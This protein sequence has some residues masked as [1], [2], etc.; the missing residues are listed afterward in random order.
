MRRPVPREWGEPRL[1][2]PDYPE[3]L[4]IVAGLERP[5][6]V[7]APAAG[8]TRLADS[9]ARATRWFWVKLDRDW[10]WNLAR[11]LAYTCLQALFAVMGLDVVLLAI[12]LRL[13]GPPE[14]GRTDVLTAFA[15][16]VL[17][18]HLA[19]GTVSTFAASLRAVPTGL[20]LLALPVAIWYGSRFFVVLESC[21]CVVFRREQRRFWRQNGVALAMLGVLAILVP[22]VAV[23]AVW[24]PALVPSAHHAHGLAAL[25]GAS[26]ITG[27]LAIAVGL[28]ANFALVLLCYTR[29]TPGRI[30]V[31]AAWPGALVAACLAELYLLIFPVYVRYVLQPAHFGSVAGFVLVAVVFFYAYALFMIIGAEVTAAR[32]RMPTPDG[33]LTGALARLA[34][35][36]GPVVVRPVTRPRDLRP[37]DR[38]DSRD[39]YESS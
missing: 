24:L 35:G 4:T 5:L 34:P 15:L 18:D 16:R 39:H 14:S 25:R 32:L 22:I 3:D 11:L 2:E 21:L 19:G 23:S 9:V 17:P 29:V 33:S 31:R 6:D 8:G 7:A 30:P 26:T 38:Y 28:G 13:V 36:R 1:G 27:A 10:G 20:L 37:R 12:A